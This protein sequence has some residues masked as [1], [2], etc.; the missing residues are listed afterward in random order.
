MKTVYN[1]LIGMV[2]VLG[3]AACDEKINPDIDDLLSSDG[4]TDTAGDALQITD[5]SF[6]EDHKY[7]M[8]TA[9]LAHET[10]DYDLMDSARVVVKPQQQVQLLPGG[11]ARRF[12]R[13]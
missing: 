8:L 2:V 9:R 4:A 1:W 11:M 13:K 10:G 6:S 3:L 12:S 5:I 7:E